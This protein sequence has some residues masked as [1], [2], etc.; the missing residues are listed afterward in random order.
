MINLSAE[1]LA[2]VEAKQHRKLELKRDTLGE[3]HEQLLRLSAA[4]TGDIETASDFESE[5][6][7]RDT[8]SR[9]LAAASD[10][11][12]KVADAID[13]GLPVTPLLPLLPGLTQQ[14]IGRIEKQVAEKGRSTTVTRLVQALRPAAQAARGDEQVAQLTDRATPAEAT[15]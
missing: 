9:S 2:S 10:A 15:G 13:K 5:M 1:A 3:S 6:V 7:W 14:M 11:I 8:E 4:M 12:Y